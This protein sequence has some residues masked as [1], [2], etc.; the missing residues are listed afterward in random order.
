MKTRVK[1]TQSPYD[2]AVE[3]ALDFLSKGD[4]A[5][6]AE[7]AE[8]AFQLRP[9]DA[10]AL[11]LYGLCL[12][13]TPD[14]REVGFTHLRRAVELEPKE[15]RWHV[16]LGQ[17]LTHEKRYDDAEKS[18]AAAAELSG[19]HSAIV[20]E[21]G[22]T[23]FKAGR[24]ADAS[25]I[26]ARVIQKNPN[27]TAAWFAA[28]EALLAAGDTVNAV[29]AYEKAHPAEGRS[30][31]AIAQLADLNITLGHYDKAQSFNDRLLEKNAGNPGA[32]L[33]AAN[34]MRWRGDIDAAKTLQEKHWS[35]NKSHAGL[36]A[37]LLHDGNG[38]SYDN[39]KTIAM[40]E[41]LSLDDRRHC[42]FA[43]CA[44]ADKNKDR[45]EAWEWAELANSLYAEPNSAH[46]LDELRALLDKAIAA[47]Q[48]I[49]QIKTNDMTASKLVYIIGPPRSGGSLLQT[50]LSRHPGARSVGER[51]ALLGFIPQLL[52]H[53]ESLAAQTEA[54]AKADIAGMVRAVGIADYFI[55]KT[56][57]YFLIA[58]LLEK[59]HAGA[60]FVAPYRDMTDMAVSLYFHE[61]G[62]EFPFTRSLQDIK[63]Y[64][65][66]HDAALARWRDVGVK[67]VSHNHDRFVQDTDERGAALC[68]ALGF[69]W[70]KDMLEPS[71]QDGVVRTFSARQVRNGVS[72]QYKGRGDKYKS[73]LIAAGFSD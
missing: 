72:G 69:N 17:G 54:L 61:F 30:E 51:G 20:M 15:P 3:A 26:Y 14:T 43:L 60:R 59:V 48:L 68:E 58:G 34:L 67:I 46:G 13:K 62:K 55:D 6:A 40:D 65:D 22:R 70:S 47:Y 36:A 63:D 33:R 2:A 21:W 11:S 25:Q 44:Y 19:G 9:D 42:A 29:F 53:P 73:Y 23:V 1:L 28:Y 12:V 32:G 35:E 8:A 71:A 38:A 27:N 57:H 66:F 24:P 4:D 64:L 45:A 37:A 16:H 31:S 49:P 52:D 39:A 10:E 7:Y 41:A 50:I 5:K 18:Y 56:P